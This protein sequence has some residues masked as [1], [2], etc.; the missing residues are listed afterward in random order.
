MRLHASVRQAQLSF[1]DGHN[2]L[3]Q[4]QPNSAIAKRMAAAHECVV[5]HIPWINPSCKLALPIVIDKHPKWGQTRKR[6][7]PI[8][9][10]NDRELCVPMGNGFL[11]LLHEFILRHLN[12]CS[13]HDRQRASRRDAGPG[14]EIPPGSSP[15]QVNK[16][17]VLRCDSAAFGFARASWGRVRLKGGEGQLGDRVY[18]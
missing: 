16:V 4:V 8:V 3:E 1:C 10:R 17:M 12:A 2:F 13:I 7:W 6:N 9:S 15:P 14:S 11:S 5:L 18:E